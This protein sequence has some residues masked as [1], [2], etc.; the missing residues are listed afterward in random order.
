MPLAEAIKRDY[1]NLGEEGSTPAELNTLVP[2]KDMMGANV[3]ALLEHA[4]YQ[5]VF[6]GQTLFE[7]GDY[8]RQTTYLLSGDVQ[9]LGGDAAS[10][11]VIKGRDTILP[12]AH[13]QP[14]TVTATA[15]SDC[16]ILKVDSDRLDKLLTWSQISE[17]LALDFSYQTD[18]DEDGDWIAT[19]L[20]S[21]L[22][23]KVP[24]INMTRL[25]GRLKPIVVEAG[26]VILRQGEIGDGCYFIKDGEAL[27]SRSSSSC[28]ISKPIARIAEGR[29]FGEDA[30]VNE[31][32]RNATVTMTTNGVLMR[33]EKADFIELLKPPS[34]L[35]ISYSALA[36]SG[37][38]TDSSNITLI[39]VRSEEEYNEG[40][41][42]HAINIPLNLLRLKI[43]QLDQGK[44]YVVVCNTGRR[45]EAATYLLGKQGFPARWLSGGLQALSL[46]QAQL[47]CH[48]FI[49]R[50]GKVHQG[51]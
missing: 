13:Q 41:L 35:S 11:V 45:S 31:T 19:L 16:R 50:Q 38:L 40:H 32:V 10:T 18:L 34:V 42:P 48:D 20:R 39:D 9:L 49:L 51:Q 44:T 36:D 4:E 5:V 27:V 30:L 43:R 6:A 23:F 3:E 21:N 15:L 2:L 29:C 1:L 46:G 14:R 28:S 25:F 8:D 33:M 17:Y 7:C 12:I 37:A 24:P 26:D 22:F 47:T